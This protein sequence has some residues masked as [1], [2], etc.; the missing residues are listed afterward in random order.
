[1]IHTQCDSVWYIHSVCLCG[2]VT[3][4]GTL[5]ASYTVTVYGTDS[6]YD[7]VW[8]SNFYG[9]LTACNMITVYAA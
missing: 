3:V 5:T 1:M 4:Y 9:T 8:N 7:S 6:V 2:V